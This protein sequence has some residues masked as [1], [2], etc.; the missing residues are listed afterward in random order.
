MGIL[1]KVFKKSRPVLSQLPHGSF[2]VDP[3]GRVTAS[4]LPQSFPSEHVQ[5]ISKLVLSA[6]GEAKKLGLNLTELTIN[7]AGLR[8]VAKEMRGGA[9]V[10]LSPRGVQKS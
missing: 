5:R 7:Y 4:T 9:L 2:S 8:I 1:K 3:H 10:I 6:F